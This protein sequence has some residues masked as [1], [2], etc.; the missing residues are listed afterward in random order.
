LLPDRRVFTRSS[1]SRLTNRALPQG[2]DGRSA[3]ARRYRDILH[4]L[5]RD[6]PHMDTATEQMARRYAGLALTAECI[7]R[8]LLQGKEVDHAR[9]AQIA[10]T[11]TRLRNRLKGTRA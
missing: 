2:V 7:E 6:N 8:D 5:V 1:L 10:Q 11:M 9:L 4:A 3:P